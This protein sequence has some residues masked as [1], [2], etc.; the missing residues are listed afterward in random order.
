[1]AI[2]DQRCVPASVNLV[3]SELLDMIINDT[4]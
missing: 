4:D 2:F 1:M 3:K